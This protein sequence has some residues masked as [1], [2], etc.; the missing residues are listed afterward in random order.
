MAPG[1]ETESE[2]LTVE[3][4]SPIKTDAS[5][6][7]TEAEP[8]GAKAEADSCQ[9]KCAN[10]DALF[11]PDRF[12]EHVCEFDER[13]K[14]IEPSS[15]LD[16]HPCFRQ[17]DEN[18]EQWKRL[19][20]KKSCGEERSEVKG[21]RRKRGE[22]GDRKV[23]KCGHCERKFVHASGLEKHLARMHPDKENEVVFVGESQNQDKKEEPA[24]PFKVCLKCLKCGM[25]FGSL[26]KMMEH[27]E[28]VDWER[29]L[30]REDE[31][32]MDKGKVSLR[33]AFR[34]VILT[35]VF[36]C[37][38]CDK[39][40]SDLPSLFEHESLHDP[41]SGYE[42][43]L[44]EIRIPCMK[45][46]L[47][48]RLNECVF[49]D[50]WNEEFRSLSKYFACN[51]CDEHFESLGALYEHRYA[52]YHWFPRLSRMEENEASGQFKVGCES[53][54]TNFDNAESILTHYTEMHAQKRQSNIGFRRQPAEKSDA[55]L[56]SPFSSTRP[57]LCELCG[58]TYTQSSHLW[59]HLRFHNGIRPFTCPESGCNR[60]FTIRP[61]LKDHIRKCHTGERPYHC[62]LCDKRFLTGSVYYQHRLIH[63]GERRYG[64]EECGKRFYRADA[65]K[66][67]QRIHSGEKPY[68]CPHCP[69]QFRQRG[70]RE[71][72]IRVKHSSSSLNMAPSQAYEDTPRSSRVCLKKQPRRKNNSESE[73]RKV[74]RQIHPVEEGSEYGP[75]VDDAQAVYVGDVSLPASLFQP[76]LNDIDML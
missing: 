34:I 5:E 7:Q 1:T 22:I 14:R 67:H 65:L 72:H 60:S 70:D 57:Y 54:G 71:K 4:R 55:D 74:R 26:D 30:E 51:V 45:D 17:L 53:C 8:C 41:A 9:I 6:K 76:I 43:T 12:E 3:D 58:K 42:C 32:Y 56:N 18:M 48:H 31:S 61:D 15:V 19:T 69:K 10:C 52:N 73:S 50:A 37:E 21:E 29:E 25:V 13:K 33:K 44:C 16:G 49:R 39:H 75:L 68:S 63:R 47:F 11:S 24:D 28:M 20:K 59:Q 27:L 23:H 35:T 38:F 66:N 46:M 40:F 64:C 62:D 2:Q 36:Q